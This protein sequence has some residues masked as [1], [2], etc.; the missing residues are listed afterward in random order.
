MVLMAEDGGVANVVW[1]EKGAGIKRG[2]KRREGDVPN[3]L[4]LNLLIFV[5]KLFFDSITLFLTKMT[6]LSEHLI[7][8]LCFLECLKGILAH[9]C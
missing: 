6:H 9:T 3:F 8:Y 5:P 2:R 4:V 1:E 7:C